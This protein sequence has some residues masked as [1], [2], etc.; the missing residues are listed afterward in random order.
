MSCLVSKDFYLTLLI[1]QAG[2]LAGQ[3]HTSYS[4]A[5]IVAL[6]NKYPVNYVVII[7]NFTV[8]EVVD[9]LRDK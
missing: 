2:W 4:I 7:N 3:S 5:F 6:L 1:T 9:Q 8:L